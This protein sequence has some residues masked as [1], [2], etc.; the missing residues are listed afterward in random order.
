M[1]PNPYESPEH[2]F[3]RDKET[4]RRRNPFVVAGLSLLA[5]VFAADLLSGGM[6]RIFIWGIK[7]EIPHQI[8]YGIISIASGALIT[9]R[10]IRYLRR[11]YDPNPAPSSGVSRIIAIPVWAII[12]MGVSFDVICIIQALTR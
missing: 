8:A 7:D 9:E 6:V 10:L 11:G 2:D 12:S 4:L 1:E 3:A 5:L